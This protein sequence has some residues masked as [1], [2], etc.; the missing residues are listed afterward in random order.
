M[1]T[2]RCSPEHA[3]L[4]PRS[5]ER[6]E[7]GFKGENYAWPKIHTA[8]NMSILFRKSLDPSALPKCF[9]ATIPGPTIGNYLSADKD[10]PWGDDWGDYMALSYIWCA[11]EPRRTITMNS[12]PFSVSPQPLRFITSSPA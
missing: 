1:L 12:H 9:L 6:P 7:R 4:S 10:L 3:A 8:C 5:K 11:S 2:I